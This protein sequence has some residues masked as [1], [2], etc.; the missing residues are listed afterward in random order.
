MRVLILF[1]ILLLICLI[2]NSTKSIDHF[3]SFNPFNCKYLYNSHNKQ[4]RP[5][6][7]DLFN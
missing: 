1:L 3:V 5:F 2:G 4:Y 7:C 6:M